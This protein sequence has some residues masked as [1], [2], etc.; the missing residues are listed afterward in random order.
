MAFDRPAL[1]GAEG[2]AFWK[3]LG[4]GRGAAMG[5]GADLKRW[6]LFAVWADDAAL[7]EFLARSPVAARWRAEGEETWSIRLLYAGGHGRWGGWDPFAGAAPVAAAPGGPLAVLTRASIRLRRLVPFY[8]SAPA[9]S[10]SL[11]AAQ[12]C[13]RAVGMGEWPVA[14]QATFSVWRDSAAIDAFAY[15]GRAHRTVIYRTRA[16]NWYS[17]ECFARFVPYGSEG[18]WGGA[19]P[20]AL[21]PSTTPGQPGG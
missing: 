8:R 14:R 21:I 20:L 6:A 7:D 17:E 9:V 3:L 13:L 12:G 15:R 19:D 4:T 10:S 11:P 5:L 16:E 18:T 1:A 2:L